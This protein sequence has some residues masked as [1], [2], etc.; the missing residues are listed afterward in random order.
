MHFP[1]LFISAHMINEDSVLTA[2]SGYDGTEVSLVFTEQWAS[3]GSRL[4]HN[5]TRQE[6]ARMTSLRIVCV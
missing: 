6:H 1:P 3:K 4:R 5:S 2:G